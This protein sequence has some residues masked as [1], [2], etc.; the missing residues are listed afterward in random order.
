MCRLNWANHWAFVISGKAPLVIAKGGFSGVFPDSS[1]NAY[2]FAL[3]STSGDTTLWCDVQLTKDGV[4]ICLRDLLMNNC[5]SIN[6]AYPAGEKAYI[7]NGQRSKGWFPIDYTISSLQSVIGKCQP[8]IFQLFSRVHHLG[9]KFRVYRWVPVVCASVF[10]K[11]NKSNL[12]GFG[13]WMFKF[14]FLK[15]SFDHQKRI[16]VL[17]LSSSHRHYMLWSNYHTIMILK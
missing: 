11:K 1:Q 5:T 2:V 10:F 16:M 4:G 8:I 17:P 12:F 13:K 7:V 6:Q 15:K 14:L 3:S 9:P